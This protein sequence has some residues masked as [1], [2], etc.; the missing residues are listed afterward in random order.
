MAPGVGVDSQDEIFPGYDHGFAD[1]NQVVYSS[2]GDNVI[3]GLLDNEVYYVNTLNG[4][5][6][7][8][9]VLGRTLLDANRDPA[10][11]FGLGDVSDGLGADTID[12]GYN[13]GFQLGDTVIYDSG[14][15]DNARPF[16]FR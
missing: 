11:L 13:H 15:T 12:L 14:G 6:D 2:G 10:T 5:P 8:P 9:F 4:D 16:R 7:A 1:G 3:E